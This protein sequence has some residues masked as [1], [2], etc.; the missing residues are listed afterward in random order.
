MLLAGALTLA[1]LATPPALLVLAESGS[2][3]V[4]PAPAAGLDL[5]DIIDGFGGAAGSAPAG[6][7]V[8]GG[9]ATVQDVPDTIDRGLRLTDT[10]PDQSLTVSRSLGATSAPVVAAAR[11]RAGQTTSVIG[12]HLDS[13]AGHAATV[14]LGPD[15]RLYA[16]N[17]PEQVTIGEYQANEWLDLRITTQPG[18]NTYSVFLRGKRLAQD[19]AFR[20]AAETLTNLQV[21][22]SKETTGTAWIDDVRV[23]AAPAGTDWAQIGTVTP[24]TAKQIGSSRLISGVET[25]GRNYARFSEYRRQLAALGTTTWRVMPEWNDV[26]QNTEGKYNWA[27]TDE[28]INAAVAAGARPWVQFSYGSWHYTTKK[29]LT[30]GGANLGAGLPAGEGLDKAENWCDALVERYKDRVKQYEV[31]NEPNNDGAP[32]TI[33]KDYATYF[34]RIA[35]CVRKQQPDAVIYATEFGIS[36]DFADRFMTELKNLKDPGEAD[37]DTAKQAARIA[38]VNGVAYHPYDNYPD[39]PKLY[40]TMAELRKTLARYSPTIVIRQGEN[41]APSTAGSFGAFSADTFTERS[42]LAYNLRRNVGDIGVGIDSSN[43]GTCDLWYKFNATDTPK[44]NSKG[45][46]ACGPDLKATYTKLSYYGLQNVAALF[47]STLRPLTRLE[48]VS[49]WRKESPIKGFAYSTTGNGDRKV[50]VRAF[51]K[52]GSAEQAVALWFGGD[53]AQQPEKDSQGNQLAK[54]DRAPS[55]DRGTRQVDVTFPAAKMSNPVLV[56]LVSGNIYQVPAGAVQRAGSSLTIKG[57][58]IGNTPVV[59]ADRSVVGL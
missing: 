33:A 43:L 17:G 51:Q 14:G 34:K 44:I 32:S 5:A 38:L 49:D 59:V 11:L 58:P 22:V 50:T 16:Y 37:N 48:P 2:A 30:A 26:E 12:L 53:P 9:A 29:G 54:P 55:E 52:T 28:I 24:R 21:G 20:V 23:F 40:N 7:A 8:A 56:D 1:G 47:D 19:L 41:N 4:A 6:W 36:V 35:Q 10:S 42:Q 39:N 57:V 15:K 25:T 31:W 18:T 27:K 13:P 3:Q 45:V 46:V